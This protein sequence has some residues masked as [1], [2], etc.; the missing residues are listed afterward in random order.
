MESASQMA[1]DLASAAQASTATH[2]LSFAKKKDPGREAELARV[3]EGRYV[4]NE[5]APGRVL[6][7]DQRL[8]VV[9]AD[10]FGMV[11]IRLLRPRP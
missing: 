11:K 4:N 6:N 2:S 10:S 7:G 9:P 5:W 8:R 1:S 3:E